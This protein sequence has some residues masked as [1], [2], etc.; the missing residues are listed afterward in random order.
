LHEQLQQVRQADRAQAE[1][2]LMAASAGAGSR[3]D[4]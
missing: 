4:L 1:F 2:A 3:L